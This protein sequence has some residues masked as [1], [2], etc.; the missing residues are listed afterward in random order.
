MRPLAYILLAATVT[1]APGCTNMPA[2]QATPPGQAQTAVVQQN[3]QLAGQV[4]ALNRDNQELSAQLARQVQQAKI[5]QDHLATVR[6]QLSGI[7]SQLAQLRQEKDE[8]TREYEVLNASV[9]RRGG[10]TI[11]PN[12]SLDQ[13]LPQ[14]SDPEVHVR[15]DGDVVRVELPASRLFQAGGAQLQPTAGHLIDTVAGE[16]LRVYPNQRI[17]IEGHTD[18]GPVAGGQWRSHH[19][20]SAS[21]AAAV[22]EMVTTRTQFQGPQLFIA[23]HG[24][25]QP[26]LSNA[27]AGGRQR[28]RR[29]ELVV[30]PETWR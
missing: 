30:Y 14:V 8:V 6:Q 24:P 10:V 23:A 27:T 3:T 7:T 17:G 18:S 21:W 2:G 28:N 9:R 4:E 12:N 16:L 25:N 1:T 5:L 13:S 11:R 22:Y 19:Q 26:L 20:L 29:V 15:R